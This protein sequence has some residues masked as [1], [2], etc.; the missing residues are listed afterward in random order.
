MK[1][2]KESKL[3]KCESITWWLTESCQ[4]KCIWMFTCT[5]DENISCHGDGIVSHS[6]GKWRMPIYYRGWSID[7]LI[8]GGGGGG[9]SNTTFDNLMSEHLISSLTWHFLHVFVSLDVWAQTECFFFFLFVWFMNEI[10]KM[11]HEGRN[12]ADRCE[13]SKKNMSLFLI[14]AGLLEEISTSREVLF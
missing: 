5:K 6:R 7:W 14:Q 8:D 11:Q 9:L 13:C 2:K 3:S 12:K 1:E 10:S 4:M